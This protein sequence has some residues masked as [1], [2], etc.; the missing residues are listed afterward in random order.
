METIEEMKDV[1]RSRGDAHRYPSFARL[2]YSSLPS[3][4]FNSDTLSFG[5]TVLGHAAREAAFPES[6]VGHVA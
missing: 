5:D 3:G 6:F 4:S 1:E 2:F